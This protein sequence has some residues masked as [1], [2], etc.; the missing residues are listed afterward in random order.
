MNVR[1][2]PTLASGVL[3]NLVVITAVASSLWVYTAQYMMPTLTWP[4][5]DNLPSVCRMLSVDCL[6][7][8]FFT[9]AS[10]DTNPRMPFIYL[11]TALTS[12]LDNGLGAGLSLL[13]A[14]LLVCLPMAFAGFLL[15]GV[16]RHMI[17]RIKKYAKADV[18]RLIGAGSKK[19]RICG[20]QSR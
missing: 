7:T 14:V 6:T 5:V 10:S 19:S 13:R 1:S 15:V 8:D 3:P 4:A 9:D 2:G 17:G 18:L 20:A 16:H 11:V 12:V